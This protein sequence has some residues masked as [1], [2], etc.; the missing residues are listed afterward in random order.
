LRCA[1]VAGVENR[2]N[3]V[4]VVW[5]SQNE[6]TLLNRSEE[7]RMKEITL[8]VTIALFS[9][10]A[11]ADHHEERGPFYAFYHFAAPDPG[12]VVAAMDKFW[13]SDCGKQ[14]PADSGLQQEVF[15]G[16][17]ASTHFI[18]NTFQNAADQQ[19][20]AE[21]LS[22][23]PSAIAFLG[24]MTAA[25]VEPVSQYIGMAPIDENDWGQD[26]VF[27][28]YDIIVEPQNQAAFAAAFAKMTKALSKNTDIR[29]YGLGGIG[30]GQDK[31][32]HW[33]WFGARSVVEMDHINAQISGHPAVAEF[34]KTVGSLRT[35]VNSSLIQNVKNYPRN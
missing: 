25:G 30:Y 32:T 31:F 12:A 22:T 3:V 1:E 24:D 17:Y 19:K 21:I 16:G 6:K 9:G 20:A 23:C 27:T 18:I 28:K 34:Y 5:A 8:L 29:S 26:S 7:T 4:S 15:N 11:L 33:A 14:F 13:A 35:L 10:L 2:T